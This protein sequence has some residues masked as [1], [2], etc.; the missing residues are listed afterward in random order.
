MDIIVKQMENVVMIKA[1]NIP[2]NI[3]EFKNKHFAFTKVGNRT[4]FLG[5]IQH[6][7]TLWV[8]TF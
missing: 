7:N 5:F 2:R 3:W 1:E 6:I 4:Y 8:K